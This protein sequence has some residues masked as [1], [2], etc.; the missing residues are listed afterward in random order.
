MLVSLLIMLTQLCTSLHCLYHQLEEKSGVS[1]KAVASSAASTTATSFSNGVNMLVPKRKAGG[2]MP[3]RQAVNILSVQRKSDKKRIAPV[4]MSS[5]IPIVSVPVSSKPI[6]APPNAASKENHIRNI[7]GPVVSPTVSDVH[8]L[9]ARMTGTLVSSASPHE[10]D[11]EPL[12]SEAERDDR[13]STPAPVVT[14]VAPSKSEAKKSSEPSLKRKRDGE[15][16]A[17]ANAAAAA[18]AVASK[19]RELAPRQPKLLNS[20][21]CA[22]HTGTWTELL[23][24]DLSYY[25][26]GIVRLSQRAAFS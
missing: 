3:P 22:L 23:L 8:L 12:S 13:S 16:I 20:R 9:D 15:R 10:M 4:L 21:Y 7:L 5:G 14:P 26:F 17:A 24:T 18:Q 11:E 19:A 1:A 2:G 6:Q 25:V